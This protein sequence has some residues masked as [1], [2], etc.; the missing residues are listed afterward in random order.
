[1]LHKSSNYAVVTN[2]KSNKNTDSGMALYE[3]FYNE[4]Y[5]NKF[6]DNRREWPAT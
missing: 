3:S 5:D 6:K 4:I 2:N 1:M